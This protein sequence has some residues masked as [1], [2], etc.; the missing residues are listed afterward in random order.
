MVFDLLEYYSTVRLHLGSQ[1]LYYYIIKQDVH[2]E[3]DISYADE[4]TESLIRETGQYPT[5]VPYHK[6]DRGIFE[7]M[8][9]Y[10]SKEGD[11]TIIS[12]IV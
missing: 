12:S 5:G 9:E 7:T 6:I 8:F 11:A 4:S 2:I 1:F 3:T 10:L